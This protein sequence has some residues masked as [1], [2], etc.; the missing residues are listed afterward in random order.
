M[1]QPLLAYVRESLKPDADANAALL[2]IHNRGGRRA[3][4]ARVEFTPSFADDGIFEV[5][6]FASAPA[7]GDDKDVLSIVFSEKD[8]LAAAEGK[9]GVYARVL[10]D[11]HIVAAASYVRIR[12]AIANSKHVGWGFHGRLKLEYNGLEPLTIEDAQLV[13]VAEDTVVMTIRK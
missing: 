4:L 10:S 11:E 13:F 8:N 3:V 12:L 7:A 6:P 2:T 5:A 9:H 1:L